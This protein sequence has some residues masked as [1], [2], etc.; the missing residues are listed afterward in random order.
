MERFYEGYASDVEPARALARAQ[1]QMLVQTT[2]A[3]PFYWA[4]FVVAEGV[5][6][7]GMER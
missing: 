3:H 7:Q 6:R 4:G 2:T 5:P 1:R